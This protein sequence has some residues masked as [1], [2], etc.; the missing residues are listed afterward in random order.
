MEKVAV[1]CRVS[2]EEQ[3]ERQSINNQTEYAKDYCQRQA[4]IISDFY[5]DDGVSGTIPFE[6]REEG[7]RLLQDAKEGKFNLVL[8]WKID[9]LARDT[10]LSL[11]VAHFLKELGINIKSMTEPF[12]TSTP[13]GEF[14]FTQLASIAKLERD[15]IRERSMAGTNRLARQGKWLGGIVPYG[16]RV[17]VESFLVVNEEPL[18][19]VNISEAEVVRM[20]YT[21]IGVDG[22]STLEVARR[23]NAMN[24]PSHYAKDGREF[25]MPS[26]NR[27]NA[28]S[29]SVLQGKRKIK[30]SGRWHPHRIGNMVHNTTYMGVHYYGKRTKKPRELIERE[31]PV[32][33]SPELW[34]KAQEVLRNN[35]LWA[36]RHTRREYLLRGL[37]RCDLCGRNMSGSFHKGR[38]KEFERWYR[39]NGKLSHVQIGT[40]Y[41]ACPSKSVKSEW[42]ET[43]VWEELR[44]W[45]LH[46]ESLELSLS[47]KL[48]EY[49]N[50]KGGW[51]AK[52]TS[53]KTDIAHKE[54]ERTKILELYRKGLINITD[55][56]SQLDMVDKEK[57]ELEGMVS[58]LK[59]RMIIGNISKPD[60]ISEIS[61]QLD[62]FRNAVEHDNIPWN[63]KRRIVEM[64][65]REIQINL[66]KDHKPLVLIETIPFRKGI[67]PVISGKDQP[68]EN[69]YIRFSTRDEPKLFSLGHDSINVMYRFPLPSREISS[70]INRMDRG[71]W[72]LPA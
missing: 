5:C 9:R 63:E 69:L 18:P 50:E 48:E 47:T 57:I 52:L 33:V 53:I 64:F 32:I 38:K 42:I 19:N 40:G 15:N 54:E 26:Q 1:Y 4:Y 49:E 65:V 29:D 35:F 20:I 51:F 41:G 3:R 39:C 6:D 44:T 2:T 21:W 30:T 46:R 17:N 22:F 70:I 23:L 71:S 43:L 62:E 7:R 25:F 55:V 16:Y 66:S 31:V 67:D 36:K 12:D 68:I 24:I 8:I 14:M 56:E 59:A 58:E 72:R 60:V 61:A 10:K 34:Y 13:I 45:I 27:K 37:I 28:D 11:T